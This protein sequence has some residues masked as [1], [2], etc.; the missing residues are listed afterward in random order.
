MSASL[1]HGFRGRRGG[2]ASLRVTDQERALL[3]DLFQ[4]LAALVEPDDNA[5][6]SSDPLADL[7]GIGD[8]DSLPSDPALARLFP[9]AYADTESA[10]DFRRFTEARM[11]SEKMQRVGLVLASLHGSGRIDL[12]P[13]ATDA[14]L[15][16]LTDLRLVLAARLDIKDESGGEDWAVDVHDSE[17]D[18]EALA[19][20]HSVYNWLGWLHETLVAALW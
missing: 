1:A 16:E 4:Q 14:W 17:R 6:E 10:S 20:L 2:G 11:R 5:V 9:D 18:N 19:L 13:T 15:R 12:D 3:V 8:A 7:V